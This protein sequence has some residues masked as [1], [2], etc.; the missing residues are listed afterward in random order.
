M[1]DEKRP[2]EDVSADRI[3]DNPIDFTHWVIEHRV[4]ID[5]ARLERKMHL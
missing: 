1:D 5:M 4:E 2:D 3:M